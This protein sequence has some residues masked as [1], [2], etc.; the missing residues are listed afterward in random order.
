MKDGWQSQNLGDLLDIQSGYAFKSKLFSNTAGMPLIRIRD[1]K[2]SRA[3]ETFYTGEYDSQYV[4]TN[5]DLL[6]GMD[7]EFRCHEWKGGT[8]LLNQRVCKLINFN[9]QLDKR[10]LL[11]GINKYLK[12]IED[13]TPFTTVKHLSAKTIRNI[14]FPLPPLDEQKRIVSILDQAFEGLDRARANAEANLESVEELIKSTFEQ[15]LRGLDEAQECAL[16]DHIELLTGFAFKSS[17][18]VDDPDGMRLIR[19]DNVIPGEMRWDGAKKW[20]RSD[21]HNYVKYHLQAGDL[22]IAMD[23]T[24][25][26]SGIKYAV[27]TE[28][29]VPSMLVQR[30]ARLRPKQSLQLG[31]LELTIGSRHFEQYVLSIQT[32]SGVPH[33][34]GDQIK[35]YRLKIPS[36]SAQTRISEKFAKLN[37]DKLSLQLAYRH[38]LNQ[39]D[40]LRQS[41]LQKAFSGE[42]T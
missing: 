21:T 26:K 6:I 15:E 38:T 23:R 2:N 7:G 3:T 5:D 17:G 30:V 22:L 14:R 29:D 19:G 13:I 25:I 27:L 42:L 12:E 20:P 36:I 9:D 4:V 33:V 31:F 37:A 39:A 18:Y 24:W 8:A 40:E 34:S 41:I 11:Y 32:G 28:A 10:F 16:S 1:L 35:Q